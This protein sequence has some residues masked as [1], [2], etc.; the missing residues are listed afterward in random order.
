[1]TKNTNQP[2]KKN[3]W[4][5]WTLVI[6]VLFYVAFNGRA[7]GR[8]LGYLLSGLILAGIGYLAFE[9]F[10]S[11]KNGT[12]I[13]FAIIAGLVLMGNKPGLFGF[14]GNRGASFGNGLQCVALSLICVVLAAAI[15]I[16]AFMYNRHQD[17][18]NKHVSSGLDKLD[19]KLTAQARKRGIHIFE[20]DDKQ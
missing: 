19:V 2:A 4:L 5:V 20:D 1:M 11:K 16:T 6:V 8:D 14:A 7:I 12:L 18:V 3:P 9:Y 17:E 13:A 10:R 15:A